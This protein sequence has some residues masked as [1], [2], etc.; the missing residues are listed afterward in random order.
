MSSLI[1]G[2]VPRLTSHNVSGYCRALEEAGKPRR[3]SLVGAPG[4]QGCLN[5][6]AD[7]E[8]EFT[9]ANP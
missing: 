1:F 7:T 8:F 6:E 3:A 5:G 9:A 2:P 4:S